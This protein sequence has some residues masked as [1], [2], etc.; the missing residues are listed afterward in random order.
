[1]KRLLAV[2]LLALV[3]V[4]CLATPAGAGPSV[5][6]FSG[7][8]LTQTTPRPCDPIVKPYCNPIPQVSATSYFATSMISASPVYH[9]PVSD[10]SC[11]CGEQYSA[12]LNLPAGTVVGV[13]CYLGIWDKIDARQSVHG[14][15]TWY[16]AQ[17]TVSY[18][19]DSRVLLSYSDRVNYLKP[20]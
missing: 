8:D 20:C 1:M 2:L 18:V 16:D 17:L 10:L 13:L 14:A 5:N 4:L 11:G 15:I 9:Y 6:H 7:Y 12:S 19:P 3:A